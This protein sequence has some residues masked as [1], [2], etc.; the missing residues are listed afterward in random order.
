MDKR[1]VIKKVRKYADLV[2]IHFPVRYVILYGSC[3]KGTVRKD[4]DID[5]AVVV[6]K[7]DEDFLM[8][9]AKLYRLKRKVDERIEPVLLEKDNDKSGF[10]EEILKTGEIIYSN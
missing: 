7:I 6:D 2:S 9:E 4:S 8:S 3:A 1:E 5:V 10:L